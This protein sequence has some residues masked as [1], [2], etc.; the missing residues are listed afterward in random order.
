MSRTWKRIPS[1]LTDELTAEDGGDPKEFHAK[2]WDAPQKIG[3]KCLQLCEQVKDV[4]Q[5]TFPACADSVLQMLVAVSVE[6]APNTGRLRVRVTAD[7]NSVSPLEVEASLF[8]AAAL[9]RGEVA[10]AINR[11]RAPELSFVIA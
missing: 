8:W 4:L 3:R 6:P 10:R 1:N 7:W 5:R 9:L 2:P 11:R